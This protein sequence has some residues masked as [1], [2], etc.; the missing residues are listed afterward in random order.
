M[1]HVPHFNVWS[2]SWARGN[3][4][5]PEMRIIVSKDGPYLVSGGPPV[6]IQEIIPNEEGMSW[7]WQAGAPLKTGKNYALCRCGQSKTAPFWDGSHKTTG[8][9]G[10]GNRQPRALR[11]TGGA[12]R[13]ADAGIERCRGALRLCEVL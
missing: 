2:L 8:F 6:F 7:D 9:D 5:P 10:G 4:H 3:P 13:W 1:F 11:P 12:D